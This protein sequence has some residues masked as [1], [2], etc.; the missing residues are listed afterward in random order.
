MI[1]ARSLRRVQNASCLSLER[2]D[3]HESRRARLLSLESVARPGTMAAQS[4][5]NGKSRLTANG[6]IAKRSKYLKMI[7]TTLYV[8]VL[9]ATGKRPKRPAK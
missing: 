1:L 3:R 5:I 9:C 8:L 4:V 7:R 6:F 2:P